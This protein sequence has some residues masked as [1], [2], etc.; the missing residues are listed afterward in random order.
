[1][2]IGG[3]H[4]LL[5]VIAFSCVG[6][7][8]AEE[9]DAGYHSPYER[10]A[11]GPPE[12]PAWFPVGVWLQ[13]PANA[14]RYLDAGFNVYVG[15]WQGPTAPQLAAL[16]R[17]GMKVVCRQNEVG[18]AHVDDPTIIAW[19]HDD[20][21]DNAQPLPGGG[22]GP[23]VSPAQ[24]VADYQSMRER[25]PTRPVFL[26]LG[27][28]VAWDGWYGRGV[29]TNHPEDYPEYVRGADIV[30]FDIYPA[31]HQHEDIAG[32]LEF[33]HEGVLRLTRWAGDGGIVWN[34]VE[35]SRIDNP[36]TRPTP[37]QIRAEVWMSLIAGSRG[38]VY[39]VHQ[40]EP[41]FA[42]ASLLEDPELLE[43]VKQINRQIHSLAP[44]LNAPDTHDLVQATPDDP[45]VPVDVLVKHHED[46]TYVFAVSLRNV[47]TEVRFEIS[48]SRAFREAVRIGEEGAVPIE[49]GSF[50]DAFGGYGVRLY[51]LR[52]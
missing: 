41:T 18:M 39:F 45:D 22:Y 51:R 16:S 38:I 52:Q 47:S 34:I 14:T 10:W 3:L 48:G 50:T 2:N 21:P 17:A 40:F 19:M 11:K 9:P 27:Q 13:N 42:E 6:C 31:V 8:I 44:V 28:G 36:A 33:V 26:N 4:A 43:A 49:D 5:A 25:D 30:S 32:R 29:R 24:I 37:E 35:A 12:N 1:M 23:P 15:L 46:T 7:S 20:E